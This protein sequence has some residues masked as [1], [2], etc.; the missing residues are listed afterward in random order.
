M[1]SITSAQATSVERQAPATIGEV[2]ERLDDIIAQCREHRSRLGYFA[3]LYRN[4]TLRVKEGIEGGRFEDGDR[5]ER[6]DVTF[7]NR[8]FEAYDLYADGAPTSRCWAVAFDAAERWKPIVLKHLLVGMNAHINLDL[9]IAAAR[10]CPG[11]A[12]AGLE[13]DFREINAI[14]LDMLNDVQDAL[15]RISP[16]IRLL[17]LVGGRLDESIAGMGLTGA[18]DWAWMSAVHLAALEREDQAPVIDRIDRSIADVGRHLLNPGIWLAFK[19]LVVRLSERM[20][21]GEVMD[22]LAS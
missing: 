10:T 4:V 12:I 16:W 15:G 20:D 8:Y 3:V 11:P 18:R 22:L 17:D 9:S 14:L 21:V 7:A 2:V 19:L 1:T 6:L 5:M 13:H